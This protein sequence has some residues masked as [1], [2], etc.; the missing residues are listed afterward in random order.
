[1]YM[2]GEIWISAT[3]YNFDTY[4]YLSR[5]NSFVPIYKYSG[6][7]RNASLMMFL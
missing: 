6:K 4:F 7:W 3:M 1:M 5:T 2:C